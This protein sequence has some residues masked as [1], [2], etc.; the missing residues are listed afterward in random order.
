MILF[1]KIFLHQFGRLL[2][3]VGR[4]FLSLFLESVEKDYQLSFIEATEDSENVAPDSILISK[5]PCT[6]FIVLKIDTGSLSMVDI[7][8][9]I[10]VIFFC[11]DA[12]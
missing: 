11:T 12:G 1:V 6:V 10:C 5:R 4:S 2:N 3:L 7:H 8:T 9:S